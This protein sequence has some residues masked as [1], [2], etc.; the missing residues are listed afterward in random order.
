MSSDILTPELTSETEFSRLLG[1]EW[2]I[3]RTRAEL[4]HGMT[5]SPEECALLPP[6]P[7]PEGAPQTHGVR[8]LRLRVHAARARGS[9][10]VAVNFSKTCTCTVFH[11]QDYKLTL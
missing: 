4:H 9:G 2:R 1:S 6:A 7:A 11:R 3:L 8:T 5:A 10:P